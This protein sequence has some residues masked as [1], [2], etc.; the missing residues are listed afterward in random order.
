MEFGWDV[1][2]KM[3]KKQKS[4]GRNEVNR[5]IAVSAVWLLFISVLSASAQHPVFKEDFDH[6]GNNILLRQ[7]KRN[8]LLT[9]VG[10][11]G[12]NG[13]KALKAV[14]EGYDQ[15]SR[16]LVI[17]VPIGRA[18]KEATLCYD[19]KF[20][21]DF[22]FVRG[23]KLH[24]L[25]PDKPVTGGRPMRPDGWSARA[26]FHKNGRLS[27]Y[28]YCQNKKG[29]YGQSVMA[30]GFSFRKG[31]YYAV[32]LHVKVNDPGRANGFMHIY[33]DGEQLIRHDGV[34]YRAVGGDNTL[35][36]H[37]LF[38]TFHGGHTP[39]WAPKDKEGKYISVQAFFDN[40]T[41]FSGRHIRMRPGQ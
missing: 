8:R 34:E 20:A 7:I 12:V 21:D 19:V 33:V 27:S 39:S 1:I 24:G 4:A 2:S 15:G 31:R 6:P 25:G 22:L 10:K 17:R 30:D 36:T 9:V 23:G 41:I 28:I 29:K 40:I 37:Y 18:L 11:E 13:S 32:S 14:Y 35:I 16:R 38:S 26:M 5:R 3:N